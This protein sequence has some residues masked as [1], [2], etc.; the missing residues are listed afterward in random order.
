MEVKEEIKDEIKEEPEM[1]PEGGD[2]EEEGMEVEDAPEQVDV[3]MNCNEQEHD[4]V[5]NNFCNWIKKVGVK[6]SAKVRIGKEGSCD[7]YGMVATSNIEQDEV[8]FTI[9]KNALLCPQTCS[10]QKILK[11]NSEDLSSPSNWCQ[12]I[13]CLMYEYLNSDSQW[14]PYLEFLPKKDSLNHPM[15][16]GENERSVLLKGTGCID[17]IESDIKHITEEY[18]TIAKPFIRKQQN[19]G[20]AGFNV[21]KMNLELYMHMAAVVMAYSF[22]DEAGDGAPTMVPLA[23]MLNHVSDN[24]AR[25]EFGESEIAMVA[26]KPIMQGQEVPLADMLN[27][28]SDN[29][30]RLEFG[31]NEIAMVATKPIMQ[32]QEVYNT[33]G[34]LNNSQLLQNYGFVEDPQENMFEAVT[35]SLNKLRETAVECKLDFEDVDMKFQYL[36]NNEILPLEEFIVTADGLGVPA[37]F[38]FLQG[39][40]RMGKPQFEEL[41]GLSEDEYVESHF[42]EE[43]FPECFDEDE[44]LIDWKDFK[45]NCNQGLFQ[46]FK[47][48]IETLLC[49]LNSNNLQEVSSSETTDVRKF[50]SKKLVEGQK[51][52]VTEVLKQ[53]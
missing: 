38:Y 7:R 29:N 36:K 34:P 19:M 26:T 9:P 32:G 24:N 47:K 39:V 28:V 2:Q 41:R 21:E 37:D 43:I 10:I 46:I 51:A 14:L 18:E 49:E 16:W 35:V 31:E 8:L 12:L 48:S 20:V 6:V 50:L 13:T 42:E 25:L 5:L 30:A 45:E 53:L 52:L 4:K 44:Q 33:Y 23:D 3:K 15:F 1:Q 11:D 40:L 22:S 27:H 17:K